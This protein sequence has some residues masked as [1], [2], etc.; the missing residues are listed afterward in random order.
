MRSPLSYLPLNLSVHAVFS[1]QTSLSSPHFSFTT[2]MHTTPPQLLWHKARSFQ[3]PNPR[4][5]SGP[6]IALTNFIHSEVLTIF[7]IYTS[8]SG[9]LGQIL[10]VYIQMII[11][12][13]FRIELCMSEDEW[14]AFSPKPQAFLI[15]GTEAT[16]Q[17]RNPKVISDFSQSSLST[18]WITSISWRWSHVSICTY[19]LLQALQYLLLESSVIS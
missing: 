1:G 6:Y 13:P 17:A 12:H 16:A 5:L 11:G 19:H 18:Q 4:A 15:L 7:N 10:G 2:S 3:V 14:I 8:N 9:P